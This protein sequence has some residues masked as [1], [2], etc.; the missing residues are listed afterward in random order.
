MTV[1]LTFQL[2]PG[3]HIVWLTLCANT[4]LTQIYMDISADMINC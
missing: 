4:G 3:R 1:I 2:E